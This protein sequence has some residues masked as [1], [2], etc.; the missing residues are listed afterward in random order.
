MAVKN[1][2]DFVLHEQLMN[3][4]RPTGTL[5]SE[6]ISAIQI[7]SAPFEKFGR[8]CTAASF[9]RFAADEVVDKNEFVFRMTG[10]ERVFEPIV[11]RAAQ[12]AIP[13]VIIAARPRSEPERIKHNEQRVAPLP[14]IIIF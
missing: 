11:L 2:A 3:R 5:D 14:C 7:E 6:F 13:V 10:F 12:R 8:F 4:H 1:G 9:A